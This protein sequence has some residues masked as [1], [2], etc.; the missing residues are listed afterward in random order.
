MATWILH[1]RIAD[2]LLSALPGLHAAA[3]VMGNIAPDSGRAVDFGR[4]DP[5]KSVTH[6]AR[7]TDGETHYDTELFLS[8]HLRPE[9]ARAYAPRSLAFFL[10]YYAHLLTD[11]AW[12]RLIHDSGEAPRARASRPEWEAYIRAAKRDWYDTDFLYLQSHPGFRA[13]GIFEGAAG[14]END[15]MDAFGPD[16]FEVKR[17][18][19]LA[20]YREPHEGLRR[21]YPYF[22]PAQADA[23][24]EEAYCQILPRMKE[25]SFA[26]RQ[27][28]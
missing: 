2:R 27:S 10:G 24:V 8:E 16:A 17:Q 12:L 1:L 14:F 3:F 15:L 6:Y 20:F 18:E 25:Y 7:K 26:G 4:Y 19:I 23:F 13:F 5:P 21:E 28:P 9:Q 22:A 11:N